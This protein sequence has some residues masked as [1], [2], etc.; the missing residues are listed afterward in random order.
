MSIHYYGSEIQRIIN[1]LSDDKK[2]LLLNVAIKLYTNGVFSAT[3]PKDFA[4]QCIIN[5]VHFV[6]AFDEIFGKTSSSD[7]K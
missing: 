5:S 3:S 7:N 1:S 2:E 6:T 4:K